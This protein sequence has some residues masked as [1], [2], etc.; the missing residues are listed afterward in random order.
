MT[1]GTEPRLPVL[2]HPQLWQLDVRRAK[3]DE[4][5]VATRFWFSV[6]LSNAMPRPEGERV[7]E[8]VFQDAVRIATAVRSMSDKERQLLSVYR[9]YGGHD[10]KECVAPRDSRSR[11]YFV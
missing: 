9:R 7:L 10:V 3:S 8:D 2:A 11:G 4:I 5:K 1:V 6:T